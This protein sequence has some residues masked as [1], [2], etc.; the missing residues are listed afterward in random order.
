[1]FSSKAT[2]SI[3][4]L[5][6]QAHTIQ[7]DFIAFQLTDPILLLDS[8]STLNLITDKS[9]LHEIH[10]V[11]KMM[12]IRCN[13]DVTTTNLM[14]WLGDFPEIVWFNNP[15]GDANILSLFIVMKYYHV[16]F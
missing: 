13:A 8:C 4:V 10:K 9:M 3:A 12:N 11:N 15:K 5:I 14:G 2:V 7:A 16:Q 6:L 1:L